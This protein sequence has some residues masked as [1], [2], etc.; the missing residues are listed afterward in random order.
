MGTGTLERICGNLSETEGNAKNGNQC[1]VTPTG[2][3][4][5]L[6]GMYSCI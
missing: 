2:K 4:K 6:A 5:N 3:E 1:Q